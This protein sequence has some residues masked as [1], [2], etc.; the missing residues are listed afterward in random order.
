MPTPP[1]RPPSVLLTGFG[2]FLAHERNPSGECLEEARALLA[3]AGVAAACEV[4]P[5]SAARAARRVLERFGEVAPDAVLMTG[6]AAREREF[7]VERVA[8]NFSDFDEPDADGALVRESAVVPGA[9]PALFAPVDVRAAVAA[10]QSAG[11]PARV[12][13]SAGSYV[14][15][16]L[17]FEVGWSLG[18]EA[19]APPWL[20]LHVPPVEAGGAEGVPATGARVA[21]A[22]ATLAGWLVSQARR[23][24][25]R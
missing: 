6:L 25:P 16:H 22:V 15:N 17:Y 9:P 11:L 1:P 21:G 5:V 14:C 7:R 8:L 18:R 20:F 10:L 19:E 3:E 24:P 2:P 13:T 23:P 4:L 12:S